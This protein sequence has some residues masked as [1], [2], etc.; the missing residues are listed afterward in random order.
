VEEVLNNL[1][2][3]LKENPLV[4][5]HS[6]TYG[7]CCKLVFVFHRQLTS[8]EGI[9]LQRDPSSTT[10]NHLTRHIPSAKHHPASALVS[11]LP[12][13]SNSIPLIIPTQLILVT[14]V[15]T[16]TNLHMS[17]ANIISDCVSP[18]THHNRITTSPTSSS[19]RTARRKCPCVRRLRQAGLTLIGLSVLKLMLVDLGTMGMLARLSLVGRL[20]LPMLTVRGDP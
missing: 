6:S 13:P 2:L 19:H 7:I 11:R 20:S 16:I 9:I 15:I 4:Q 3:C 10:I 18:T 5:V 1:N 8:R 17:D 14:L 12:R